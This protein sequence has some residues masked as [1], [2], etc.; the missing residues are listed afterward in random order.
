MGLRI[1]NPSDRNHYCYSCKPLP[2][3]S[4]HNHPKQNFH[5]SAPLRIIPFLNHNWQYDFSKLSVVAPSPF[6]ATYSFAV[7]AFVVIGKS[8]C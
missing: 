5:I 3:P 7:V 2:F 4:H 1:I 8:G 6:E